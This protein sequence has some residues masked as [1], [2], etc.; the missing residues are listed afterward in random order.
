MS[1]VASVR[2]R[3][4]PGL[5]SLETILRVTLPLAPGPDRGDVRFLAPFVTSPVEDLACV[6]ASVL[7]R[8]DRRR[9]PNKMLSGD[10]QSLLRRKIERFTVR[11]TKTVLNELVDRDP[12][13]RPDAAPHD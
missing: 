12:E 8:L 5:A 6:S 13:P 9:G 1:R 2:R 10:E 3:C 11:R 7:D 4:L